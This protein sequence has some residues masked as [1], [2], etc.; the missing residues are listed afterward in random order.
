V[1]ILSQNNS[2]SMKKSI[3]TIVASA[4]IAATVMT[5][6]QSSVKNVEDAQ[7]N[8]QDA[9]ARVVVA[10]KE[11]DQAIRD[12]ILQFRKESEDR[13]IANEKEI[14]DFRVKIAKQNRED[15]VRNEQKLAEL[16]Q[17][18]RDMRTQL[19]EFRDESKDN[20]VAFRVKFKH[21]M[22]N[23]GHAFKNFWVKGK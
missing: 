21:D 4:F 20:W 22:D 17:Q 18:N 8:V 19:A 1:K 13:I 2:D 7:A 6:C 15:R 3:L 9:N 12:S 16:E 11:L 5:A 23:L 10:N 14:A